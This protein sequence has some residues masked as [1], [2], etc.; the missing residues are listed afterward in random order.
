ML[1]TR[2]HGIWYTTLNLWRRKMNDIVGI[3]KKEPNTRNWRV[4]SDAKA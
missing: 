2:I 4:F 1:G 3:E